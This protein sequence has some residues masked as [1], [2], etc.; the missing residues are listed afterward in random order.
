MSLR[1]PTTSRGSALRL[2]T[3]AAAMWQTMFT[4]YCAA[5][6]RDIRLS[7]RANP[8]QNASTCI[9]TGDAAS[10]RD[11]GISQRANPVQNKSRFRTEARA[12]WQEMQEA[13]VILEYHNVCTRFRTEAHASWQEMQQKGPAQAWRNRKSLQKRVTTYM[14]IYIYIHIYIYVHIYICLNI[15]MYIY[16]GT[17]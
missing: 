6:L 3:Y 15:Y 14:Y 4:M 12:S 1:T 11:I 10:L 9:E 5:S 2:H 16:V 8:V 17:D 7:Q 13:C